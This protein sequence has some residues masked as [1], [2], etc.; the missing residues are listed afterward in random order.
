MGPGLEV[1]Q[2]RDAIPG[3]LEGRATTLVEDF[4]K[5]EGGIEYALTVP[6]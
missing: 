1:W 5:G 6:T 2:G 3:T 4:E